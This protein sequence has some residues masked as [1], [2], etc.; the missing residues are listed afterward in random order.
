[1]SYGLLK[2]GA[3]GGGVLN[4]FWCPLKG[5]KVWNKSWAQLGNVIS[6]HVRVKARLRGGQRRQKSVASLVH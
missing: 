5:D 3:V 1:M 2:K 6:A 4:T